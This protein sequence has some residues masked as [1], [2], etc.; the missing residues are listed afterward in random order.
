MTT[1][2]DTLNAAF[3]TFHNKV[4]TAE[5]ARD[6]KVNDAKAAFA[7]TE[8]E[9]K[10]KLDKVVKDAANAHFD[11]GGT[12]EEFA[13]AYGK[14]VVTT[15]NHLKELGAV[16]PVGKKGAKAKFDQAK[17]DEIAKAWHEGNT[18]T[19]LE[20]ALKHGVTEPT[21]RNWAIDAGLY[22]PKKRGEAE[23][24]VAETEVQVTEPETV[25]A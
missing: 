23:E 3:S 1:L 13:E 17:R 18:R 14:S 7:K 4:D 16:V 6:K 21:M 10:G 2:N 12:L 9:A 11:N 5:Q 22:T 8:A 19:R 20:L 15:R 24:Q 25:D